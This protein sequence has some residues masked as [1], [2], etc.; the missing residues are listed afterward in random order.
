MPGTIHD[1]PALQAHL[2]NRDDAVLHGW[3]YQQPDGDHDQDEASAG[4]QAQ[5]KMQVIKSFLK[6]AVELESEQ[7]C[8]PTI[9]RCVSTIDQ[10]IHLRTNQL[11]PAAA[12][13]IEEIIEER[14]LAAM[15]EIERMRGKPPK[16]N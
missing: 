12:D 13:G 14:R 8:A 11:P 4:D 9:S 15:A 10:I 3:R 6:H 16:P 5:G 1:K 2:D 7:T